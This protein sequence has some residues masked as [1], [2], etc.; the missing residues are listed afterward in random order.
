MQ[1]SKRSRPKE[2]DEI[3][4]QL[5]MRSSLE[6]F[7]K[8][9]GEQLLQRTSAA[10][11]L[12]AQSGTAETFQTTASFDSSFSLL[13]AGRSQHMGDGNL[14]T[15]ISALSAVNNQGLCSTAQSRVPPHRSLVPTINSNWTPT[16]SCSVGSS[17]WTLVSDG[18]FYLQDPNLPRTT[19]RPSAN[20]YA[21]TAGLELNPDPSTFFEMDIVG[22]GDQ[23]AGYE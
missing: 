4:A 2:R 22:V 15:A 10:S 3:A 1:R 13:P 5:S 8:H 23:F 7:R 19:A 9:N 21:A 11:N 12:S 20:P 17:S 16:S 18:H 6:C 14:W